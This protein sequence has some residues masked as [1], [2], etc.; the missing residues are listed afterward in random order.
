MLKTMFA[1]SAL[2]TKSKIKQ[3]AGQKELN[4][5]SMMRNMKSV[6]VAYSGGVD[7]S[8]LALIATQELGENALC[9]TGISPSVS[10]IQRKQAIIIAEKFDFRYETLKTE[11]LNNPDY[12][13]NPNNRCYFCKSELYGKLS[14]VAKIRKLNFVLDGA[15]A[16]DLKDYRPGK[17][18]ANENNVLSP[19]AEMGFTKQ[20]IRERS[21]ELGLETWEKP[22]SPCLASRIQYGIPVSIER[23][24]KIERGESILRTLGFVEF[25]VRYHDKLVRI[26]I[27]PNEM[28][29]V[30][31]KQI[32]DKL[33]DSFRKLGFKYVTLDLHGFRSGALNE[34]L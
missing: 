19:L 5:R 30:L 8:Y 6:L 20:E 17:V 21:K 14:T 13:A 7:S 26:E 34:V 31:D 29:K 33:A 18:A 4:L 28:E 16:D 12:K 10:E 11:E 2:K 1:K 32:T 25:R 27:S 9:I 15:N 3:S 23:L 22:A 24:G